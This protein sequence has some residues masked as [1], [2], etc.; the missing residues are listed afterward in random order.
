MSLK[1]GLSKEVIIEGME[2]AKLFDLNLNNQVSMNNDSNEITTLYN[3]GN[4]LSK[5]YAE[6]GV[7]SGY[8]NVDDILEPKFVNELLVEKK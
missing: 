6:R 3:L 4:N 1:S 2:G 8:P 7:I 5:F